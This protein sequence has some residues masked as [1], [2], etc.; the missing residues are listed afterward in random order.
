MLS[1]DQRHLLSSRD[2]QKM[3]II[4]LDQLFFLHRDLSN[5]KKN[6]ENNFYS[7]S[8]LK[9]NQLSPHDSFFLKTYIIMI[10]LLI[11]VVFNLYLYIF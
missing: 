2:S 11:N 5:S 8:K 9:K 6:K 3:Y 1:E 7:V 4:V 10:T